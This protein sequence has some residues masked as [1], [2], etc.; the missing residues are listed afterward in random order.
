MNTI[1]L[2]W[3][4]RRSRRWFPVGR[5][6]RN[7]SGTCKYEFVYIQGA[8]QAKESAGFVGIPGFRK[9]DEQ[10]QADELFPAFANRTMN[11]GRPDRAGYLSELGLDEAEWDALSE[12]C[13]SGGLSHGGQLRGVPGDRTGPRGE[14]RDTVRAAWVEASQQ[15]RCR[16]V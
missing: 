13:V 10:Y 1:Y 14:I 2:A 15:A 9:L 3:E 12:L 7:N 11:L 16:K 8:R 4:D 5:L 6:V